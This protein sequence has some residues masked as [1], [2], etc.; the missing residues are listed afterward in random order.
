MVVRFFRCLVLNGAGLLTLAAGSAEAHVVPNMTVEAE[1]SADGRYA[2]QINVDPR[3]FL[4]SDPTSLPP[5]PASWYLDQ[6]AEQAAATKAKAQEYLSRALGLVFGGNKAPL[7]ICEILPI[8]GEDNTPLEP[9]TQE[10]HFLAKTSGSVP[11]GTASF[12][13][14]FSKDANT[15]LILLPRQ[16]GNSAA[17]PQVVF[18][19]ETSRAFALTIPEQTP[20]GFPGPKSSPKSLPSRIGVGLLTVFVLVLLFQGWRLL[21]KYR[22]HHRAHQRPKNSD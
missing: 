2:F 9:D 20:P 13:V 3:T 4:A 10:V 12:Q 6:P 19:G 11:P 22:H 1:F 18:P 21:N 7:P 17:R 15:T 5:V 16:T 8:D 14:E